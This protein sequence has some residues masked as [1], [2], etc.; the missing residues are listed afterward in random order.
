MTPANFKLITNGLLLTA[1]AIVV[2]MVVLT[3]ISSMIPRM[4]RFGNPPG[5]ACRMALSNLD[6]AKL[7][8]AAERHLTNGAVVSEQAVAKQLFGERFPVCPKGGRYTIGVIGV[9]ARCSIHGA[10]EEVESSLSH[11]N[12]LQPEGPKASR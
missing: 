5:V 2:C 8:C 4:N 3:L 9:A 6:S 12:F 11:T 10:A 7:L 1:A